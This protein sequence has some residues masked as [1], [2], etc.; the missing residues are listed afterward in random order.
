VSDPLTSPVIAQ[1]ETLYQH[2]SWG[3]YPPEGV[4]RFVAQWFYGASHRATTHLLDLGCGTG[5]VAHYLAQEGFNVSGHDGSA[6][7]IAHCHSVFKAKSLTGSFSTGPLNH[8]PYANDQFDGLVDNVSMTHN[9]WPVAQAIVS[10]AHRVLKPQAYALFVV[11]GDQSTVEGDTVSGQA[12][13]AFRHN[14]GGVLAGMPPVRCY[15]PAQLKQLL[16]PT[17]WRIHRLERTLRQWPVEATV[18]PNTLQQYWVWVQK[19]G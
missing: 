19:Q 12:D 8:L 13:K 3:Q 10:E 5:A 9:P 11:F 17:H 18:L 7:A 6:T 15:N 16:P 1:W 14:H 4:I 2:R